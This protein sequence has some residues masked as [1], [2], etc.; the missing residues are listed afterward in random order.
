MTADKSGRRIRLKF[1][2][3]GHISER[4]CRRISKQ[5]LSDIR[6]SDRSMGECE[7]CK[8]SKAKRASWTRRHRF[9][10]KS[11]RTDGGG[12]YTSGEEARVLSDFETVGAANKIEH[13]KTSANTPEQMDWRS[14]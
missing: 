9:E 4:L 11:L 5:Q 12:E 14:G 10:V 6:L 13:T 7:V 3:L 8:E 2:R 1:Q